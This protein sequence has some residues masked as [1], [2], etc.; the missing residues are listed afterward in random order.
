MLDFLEIIYLKCQ[1]LRRLLLLDVEIKKI[2]PIFVAPK[3]T[4]LVIGF[5]LLNND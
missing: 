3:F 5:L 4:A 2:G 1:N